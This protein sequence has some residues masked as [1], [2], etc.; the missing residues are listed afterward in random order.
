MW[1]RS[2]EDQWCVLQVHIEGGGGHIPQHEG[3][4]AFNAS[5]AKGEDIL[6]GCSSSQ[7]QACKG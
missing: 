1:V 6:Y 7:L 5:K 2:R 3:P 4:I